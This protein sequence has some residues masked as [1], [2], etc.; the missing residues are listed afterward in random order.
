MHCGARRKRERLLGVGIDG[1]AIDGDRAPL[2]IILDRQ[3]HGGAVQ[4][5]IAGARQIGIAPAVGAVRGISATD[6]NRQQSQGISHTATI[7]GR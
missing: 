1:A 2:Q 5:W 3:R 7:P 6:Q 4:I